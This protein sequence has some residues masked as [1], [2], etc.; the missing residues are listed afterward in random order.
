MMS[1]VGLCTDIFHAAHDK[2]LFAILFLFFPFITHYYFLLCNEYCDVCKWLQIGFLSH[3]FPVFL[4]L[5][6]VF[7]VLRVMEGL[8]A[9]DDMMA[10][11]KVKYWYRRMER[12]SLNHEG[13]QW[14]WS[15]SYK[16]RKPQNTECF[17]LQKD[18]RVNGQKNSEQHQEARSSPRLSE[19]D[20]SC[21]DWFPAIRV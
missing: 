14:R 1:Y 16:W 21:P 6:A 2:N 9:F 11:T 10:N 19:N 12:A 15:E 4:R 7:G 18:W 20:H 17:R 5:Q 13:R 3:L 8:Q